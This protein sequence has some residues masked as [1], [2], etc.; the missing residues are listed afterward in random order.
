MT[1]Y[2]RSTLLEEFSRIMMQFIGEPEQYQ[3]RNPLS[4]DD[5]TLLSQTA[6]ALD[7]GE[8]EVFLNTYDGD[9]DGYNGATREEDIEK[10][11]GKFIMNSSSTLPPNVRQACR[12]ICG[13]FERFLAEP[14]PY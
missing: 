8:Y 1:A 5:H 4:W 13:D 6:N 9:P 3:A 10:E 7:M 11:F 2:L 12:Q 14:K